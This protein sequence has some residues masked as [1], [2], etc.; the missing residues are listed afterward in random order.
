VLLLR[1]YADVLLLLYLHNDA[2]VDRD[3]Q[4]ASLELIHI[5]ALNATEPAASKPIQPGAITGLS[6]GI[7][8]RACDN[9]MA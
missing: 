7:S 3:V 2:G 8:G 9:E 1:P 6:L 5:F 4:I